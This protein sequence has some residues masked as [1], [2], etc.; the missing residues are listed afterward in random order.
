MARGQ[1]PLLRAAVRH[2]VRRRLGA[3]AGA[4]AVLAWTAVAVAVLLSTSGPVAVGYTE[5]SRRHRVHRRSLSRARRK[6]VPPD[7]QP[8]TDGLLLRQKRGGTDVAKGT[9]W[10]S[11]WYPGDQLL[12]EVRGYLRGVLDRGPRSRTPSRAAGRLPQRPPA[13]VPPGR[14]VGDTPSLG[15]APPTGQASGQAAYHAWRAERQARKRQ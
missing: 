5:L 9:W 14:S 8:S 1:L 6:L 7:G 2:S 10:V 3:Q 13:P 15:A 11:R 4:G 12:T